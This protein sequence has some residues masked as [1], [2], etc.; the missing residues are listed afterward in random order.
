MKI[1]T[2]FT[3]LFVSMW[4]TGMA[5]CRENVRKGTSDEVAVAAAVGDDW[6]S[7][8]RRVEAT[9]LPD[10]VFDLIGR[11]W[12]LVTAGDSLSFNTMTASWGGFTYVWGRPAT[13]TYI[14][15]SRYTYEFMQREEGFTLCFFA[16]RYRAA[17]RLCGTTS[18][19]DT[20]KVLEA[21]L[22]PIMTPSGLPAFAE[23]RMIIECRKMLVQELDC[24]K[25]TE[26][27]K[28]EIMK[29][30]YTKETSRHQLFLSEITGIWVER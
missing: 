20:D 15:D 21:G 1:K 5:S 25:L 11:Q 14:R 8:Y 19:R 4:V 13:I 29:S 27:Y 6:Q 17:L 26:A 2:W 28:D 30:S 22:T 16:E 23:A 10:N 9:G 3:I 18:G 12:M 7:R 24:S